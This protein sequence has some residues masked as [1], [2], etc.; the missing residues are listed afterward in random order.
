MISVNF[1]FSYLQTS[2][3]AFLKQL[4]FIQMGA[5]P[6]SS[7]LHPSQARVLLC[8]QLNHLALNI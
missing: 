5:V 4:Y 2:L 1:Q 8:G 6:A 7:I 3:C